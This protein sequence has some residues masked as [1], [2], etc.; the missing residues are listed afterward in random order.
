M[1]EYRV[2]II[3]A[4]MISHRHMTIYSKM[5]ECRVVAVSELDAAKLKAWAE[6]YGFEEKDCYSDFREML[7]RDDID[8]VDV[9]VHNNLHAP[10]AIEV[11][12][13]GFACYSE[14]PMAGSYADC[15]KMIETSK[16]LNKKFAVQISS[17]FNY[18]TRLAKHMV[19]NGDLGRVYHGTANFFSR[20]R[21]P[22]VDDEMFTPD[23]GSKKY[24]GHGVL[25]DLGVYH[26]SQ[27]LFIL[28]LPELESVYGK[29]YAEIP[30]NPRLKDKRPL[31]VEEFATGMASF[32]GN[33][34]L[35]INEAWALNITPPA[36]SW[37]TGSLGSIWMDNV[38]CGG[39][40]MARPAGSPPRPADQ[41]QHL[42]YT[43]SVFGSAADVDI[44]AYQNE[45]KELLLN[46]EMQMYNCNQ[47][48]WL[49]YFSGKLSDETR[50]NTPEIASNTALLS[51]GIFL[52][53]ELGRSVTADEIRAMSVSTAVW[54]Q[55]TPYG[56]F[57]YSEP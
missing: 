19:E 48:H 13:A 47:C 49:A 21:R 1:A 53:Q 24:G 34:S 46:P 2:A 17:I 29:A 38:D 39:G 28:G 45:K 9:C 27:M 32:K 6:R 5:P 14:K 56:V 16:K 18:Q 3:G 37:I 22:G 10:I 57:H 20:L 33:R 11:M 55:E 41:Q 36:E 8:W 50:Y 12:K 54:D 42:R 23:F 35:V 52:S 15:M 26:I 51:E 30:L 40:D 43:G 44:N 25:F 4:G 7:K 31:E